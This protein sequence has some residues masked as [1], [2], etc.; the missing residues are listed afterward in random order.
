[1]T[2]MT[3]AVTAPSKSAEPFFPPFCGN[4][5]D[6]LPPLPPRAIACPTCGCDLLS[7]R[8]MKRRQNKREGSTRNARL[9]AL[10]SFFVPGSGQ[11]FNG[12]FLK[13]FVIF[14]T[15]WLVVPWV[16]GVIDAYRS[17]RK[18]EQDPSQAM[19]L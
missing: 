2:T 15:C 18:A 16:F 11:V 4:C 10:L 5:G 13:G 9:A 14:C 1:M 7:R 12:H 8:A 3:S 17:A 19:V 6:R